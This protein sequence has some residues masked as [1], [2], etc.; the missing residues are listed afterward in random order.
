MFLRIFR[1]QAAGLQRLSSLQSERQTQELRRSDKVK[2]CR[3]KSCKGK[4]LRPRLNAQLNMR[5]SPQK[6]VLASSDLILVT[7]IRLFRSRRPQSLAPKRRKLQSLAP[8][9]TNF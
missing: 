9:P 2:N 7:T 1:L 3:G 8:A 5:S 6:L 4:G